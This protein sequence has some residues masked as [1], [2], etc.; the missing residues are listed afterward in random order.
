MGLEQGVASNECGVVDG[1]TFFSKS[2]VTTMKIVAP[3]NP[4]YDTFLALSHGAIHSVAICSLEACK[5]KAKQK[6]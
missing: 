3:L 6:N 1:Y 2:E 5:E 4:F